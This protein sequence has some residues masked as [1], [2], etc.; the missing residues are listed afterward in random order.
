[1][2]N[3]HFLHITEIFQVSKLQSSYT[4]LLS[5]CLCVAELWPLLVVHVH[6]F[7]NVQHHQLDNSAFKKHKNVHTKLHL[8]K[9]S[10]QYQP[11]KL[12]SAGDT[13]DH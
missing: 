6:V 1:M 12:L 10:A 4:S 3:S 13:C 8:Q 9:K 2:G 11:F 7:P 5:V